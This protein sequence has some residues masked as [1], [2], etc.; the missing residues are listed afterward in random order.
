MMQTIT[1]HF[2]EFDLRVV[3]SKTVTMTWRT[4]PDI[5]EATTL[6]R[7]N[8]KD[9]KNVRSFHYLG[10]WLT[11]DP[12]HPKYLNQQ[13][14]AAQGTWSKDR[15]FYTDKDINLHTR[16][17]VAEAR[18]RSRLTYALQSDRLTGRQ[19]RT[20]DSA[21]M[22]MLR[23]MVRGGFAR[24]GPDSTRFTL[25]NASILS[26]CNT[27]SASSFCQQ[28]HLRYL[29]HVYRM[30]TTHLKNNCCLHRRARRRSATGSDW[31]TTTRSTRTSS[32]VRSSTRRR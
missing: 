15:R 27:R 18:V 23:S 28:Q 1:K 22:R 2:T 6:I 10:H 13:V 31:L 26:A 24:N 17:K 20:V 25:S 14:G 30:E 21:W 5:E 3:E 4:T 11:D 16:V 32:D 9:L 12:K 7:L 19:C 29:A 8:S